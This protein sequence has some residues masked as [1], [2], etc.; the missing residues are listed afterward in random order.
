MSLNLPEFPNLDHLKKQAKSLLRELQQRNPGATLTQ[1]QHA[2]AREYGF[3][4]WPKLKAHVESLPRPANP[5]PAA[6]PAA[7]DRPARP[8]A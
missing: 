2:I 1:T 7:R 8:S 5:S 4:S 3:A 6:Q